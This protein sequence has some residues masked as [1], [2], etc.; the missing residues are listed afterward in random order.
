M[1]EIDIIF[2]SQLEYKPE[3]SALVL[4]GYYI[5]DAAEI[6]RRCSKTM[7]SCAVAQKASQLVTEEAQAIY[8]SRIF[9]V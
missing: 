7:S 9:Q 5:L 2:E 3:N 4:H 8:V 1:L 6:A